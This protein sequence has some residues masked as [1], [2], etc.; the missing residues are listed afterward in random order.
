MK[1]KTWIEIN[2]K[3]IFY[4]IGVFRGLI[5]P[6]VKLASVVKSNA[7]GH[8][9]F[10]FA[11]IAARGGVDSFCVDSIFEAET[12][13]DHGVKKPILV[14]GM[15]MPIHYAE[16]VKNNCAITISNLNALKDW[17]KSKIKPKIHIKIDTGMNRQ[18]FFVNELPQVI[19]MLRAKTEYINCIEGIYTHFAAAK[20]TNY[21][22]YT[23]IQ[24]NKF[25]KAIDL[26][27]KNGIKNILKHASASSGTMLNSRY[28]LDMVRIGMGLYGYPPSKE[29]GIQMPEIKLKPVLKWKTII[30]E[31]KVVP[32][33]SFISYDLTERVNR[34]T[35]VGIL[36][37]GYWHGL[38]WALSN[39][40]D[41]IINDKR[42]KI[43][44]RVT[45]DVAMV[46][47]TDIKCMPY[48]K[49]TID[50]LDSSFKART[51]FY[52]FLTRINPLIQ[53]VVV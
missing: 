15:T 28:H 52:E 30:S 23:E 26:F 48:D 51:S 49:V 1:L 18:G 10:D 32:K 24:F 9:L 38:P 21:P 20:D 25:K 13:R 44:G 12:L 40:G 36:P 3:A 17:I 46:D 45:M 34:E 7:Y 33:G 27:S 39:V 35:K 50:I 42:A 11:T 22:T 41:V 8:G 43:L 37:I 29:I 31:V 16:A 5:G 14:L 2:Q 4:N 53:R 6:K 47:I 19:K